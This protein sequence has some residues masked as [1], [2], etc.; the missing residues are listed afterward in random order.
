[1]RPLI[2]LRRETKN[3]QP[4]L[5]VVAWV[6]LCCLSV[7]QASL[8]AYGLEPIIRIKRTT[9]ATRRRGKQL[10]LASF[11]RIGLNAVDQKCQN[12][13]KKTLHWQL[14]TLNRTTIVVIRHVPDPSHLILRDNSFFI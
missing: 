7:G 13:V 2:Q 11:S 10:G 14:G 5:R 6:L 1:M 8:P 3:H 12:R 4:R 9:A